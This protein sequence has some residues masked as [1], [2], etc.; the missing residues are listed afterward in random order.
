MH[1]VSAIGDS[2]GRVPEPELAME[3]FAGGQLL[4]TTIG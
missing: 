2:G 4:G 3:V 1:L